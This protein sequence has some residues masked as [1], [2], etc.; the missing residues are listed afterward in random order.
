MTPL[1]WKD[2]WESEYLED[3]AEI[4]PDHPVFIMCTSLANAINDALP[5]DQ[6]SDLWMDVGE[7]LALQRRPAGRPDVDTFLASLRD[8]LY[9]ELEEAGIRPPHIREI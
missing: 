6:S 9:D 8:A 4:P 7:K 1:E 5:N 2:F 3:E